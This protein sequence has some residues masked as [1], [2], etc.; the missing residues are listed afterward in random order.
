MFDE[1]KDKEKKMQFEKLFPDRKLFLSILIVKLSTLI[2][3]NCDHQMTIT[4][5]N[6]KLVATI[7]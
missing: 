2:K 5:S 1:S 7:N 3:V 4:Q 6:V